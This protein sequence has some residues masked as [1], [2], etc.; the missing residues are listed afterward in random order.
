MRRVFAQIILTLAAL[1]ASLP[2]DAAPRPFQV[3]DGQVVITVTLNGKD[4]PALLDTGAIRSLIDADFAREMGIRS[5]RIGGGTIGASGKMVRYG[6]TSNVK[7]DIGAGAKSRSLGTYEAAEPFAPEGVHLLIG[8]D[9]LDNMAVSLDFQTMTIG[10]ERGVG[11]KAPVGE[12]FKLTRSHWLR[13]ALSVTLAD[14]QADLVFDTAASGALHL[15][16]DVVARSPEL[17]ALPTTRRRITGIDSERDR[18]SIIIPSVTLGGRTFTDVRASAGE[19]PPVGRLPMH[20]VIGVDLMKRFHLVM[21]F[22]EDR[23]W[24]TPRVSQPGSSE[25]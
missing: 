6:R 19:M 10:I 23:V 18:D 14:A 3:R 16:T 8:M 21:D 22:A 17:S 11:F 1:L 24:M 2:A 5:Q 9:V 4:L 15:H 25:P 20:G 7:L 12:P 13:P